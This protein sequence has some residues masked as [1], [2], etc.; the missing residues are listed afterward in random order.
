MSDGPAQ[1]AGMAAQTSP[2]SG[3]QLSGRQLLRSLA[4]LLVVSVLVCLACSLVG[5]VAVTDMTWYVWKIR[6]IRLAAAAIVGVGLGSA[7]MA[8]QGML[9][10]PLAEPYI[11]GISSGAG[12]GVLMGMALA[13]WTALPLWASTP[14][15]ALVGAL[16]TCAVV[17]GIAQRRGR[18]DP[19]VLLLSGVI[20]NAFN[21]A[22]MLGIYL[23][24][25][26]YVVAGFLVW[27]MGNLT[28][29][30]PSGIMLLS[31]CCVLGG[32]GV[33][34]LRGSSFN[35][36]GMGDDVAAS[37][38]VRVHWLRVETFGV[39][40][41]MTA[42]AVALAGPVG[43]VGLIVPHICRIVT[44]PDH[45]R[46]A[47]FSGFAGAIF[48]MIADTFCR[49]A[50]EWVNLGELPVGIITAMTGGPFFIYLLRRRFREAP[51]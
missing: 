9:R 13:G 5:V 7:G 25:K 36:L 8:L 15:L 3:S 28:Y 21:G 47:L 20:V 38:G 16:M 46:L 40:G 51:T 10:N 42:A 23:F 44:G 14:L 2:R 48:L 29:K 4:I 37:I 30:V 19:Y 12:V 49:T 45:R 43:F 27:A 26:P 35:A 24:V 33:L 22:V 41:L 50:G 6:L 39:V 18:L 34:F 32:W 31:G 1:S 11:L 17:Y